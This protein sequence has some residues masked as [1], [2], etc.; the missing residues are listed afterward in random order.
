M[1]GQALESLVTTP[2]HLVGIGAP[3]EP[4]LV[5]TP[6]SRLFTGSPLSFP[7]TAEETESK[8]HQLLSMPLGLPFIWPPLSLDQ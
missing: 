7:M 3:C 2:G 4:R 6:K 8:F 5:L 1:A